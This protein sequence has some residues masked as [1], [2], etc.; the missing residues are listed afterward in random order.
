MPPISFYWAQRCT[1]PRNR[2][3]IDTGSSTFH[4][5]R[6]LCWEKGAIS[7]FSVKDLRVE[8]NARM[9]RKF[10]TA[11][12]QT[13]EYYPGYLRY[14]PRQFHAMLQLKHVGIFGQSSHCMY[15]YVVPK[16]RC[17]RCISK[18]IRF[19]ASYCL[20]VPSF[21]SMIR[22]MLRKT[23]A[24]ECSPAVSKRSTAVWQWT[25]LRT[26]KKYPS[27]PWTWL[28]SLLNMQSA[29]APDEL[30]SAEKRRSS[31]KGHNYRHAYTLTPTYRLRDFCE[32]CRKVS[33]NFW[34]SQ[35]VCSSP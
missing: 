32:C 2:D 27:F 12:D 14:L 9:Y 31:Y 26:S 18:L 25:Q 5:L 22:S 1:K 28:S 34:L 8:W 16:G 17:G 30:I 29:V 23:A 6:L 20:I 13:K 7:C 24:E 33:W 3:A 21:R 10:G 15:E 19:I 35:S 11:D 4:L